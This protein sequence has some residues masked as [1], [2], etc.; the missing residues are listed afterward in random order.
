[1]GDGKLMIINKTGITSQTHE[2]MRVW[3]DE[4]HG[5]HLMGSSVL[6]IQVDREVS[7]D[8]LTSIMALDVSTLAV[9]PTP[10][11]QA[12]LLAQIQLEFELQAE[13][14]SEMM[15]VLSVL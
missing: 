15:E 8:E 3:L 5:L 14:M 6:W 4:T 2:A 7:D 1:M 13:I 9:T 11:T 12:E 10:P